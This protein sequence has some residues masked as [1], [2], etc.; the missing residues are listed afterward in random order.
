MTTKVLLFESDAEFAQILSTGLSSYGCETTVVDDGEEGISA[1]TADVPDLILLTIELPRMNGFSVCNKLKRNAGLK[2]VPLVLLSSEATEETFEQHKRL[3]TRADQ[4][5]RKPVTVEELA[6]K[7][8]GI[9]QLTKQNGEGADGEED[10]EELALDEDVE[11]EEV[12]ES[13]RSVESETDDAFGNI[14][15]AEVNAPAAD[16]VVMDDLELE[17]GD[18]LEV[19][20]PEPSAQEAQAAP[21]P[22]PTLDHGANEA[23]QSEAKELRQRIS[24][25]EEDLRS[26]RQATSAEA[27]AKAQVIQKKDAELSLLEKEIEQL[28][29][30]I[31]SNEGSGTAREFLDLRE[32]LNKKDKEILDIRDQLSS[33]EKQVV[34]LDDDNISLGRKNAD[35]SDQNTTLQAEAARLTKERDA[36]QAD[37]EQADKRGDDYKGKSERLQ[38]ELDAKIAELKQTIESHENALAT[39]EAREAALRDD[40]ATALREAALAAQEA[41]KRAVAEA[42]SQTE[43]KAAGEKEAALS[44]A[45]EEARKVREAAISAREVELKAEQDSK[46]AALHRAN[47]ESLRKL[48]AEHMQAAEE[49]AQAAEE[50]LSARQRELSDEKEAALLAQKEALLAERATVEKERDALSQELEIRTQERDADRAT[51]LERDNKIQELEVG[52][53]SARA[54]VIELRDKLEAE[55]GK[56]QRAR[57]KWGA[58]EAN[59][60][61]AKDALEGAATALSEALA[62][63]MP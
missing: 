41:Q 52:I 6:Q 58:D 49:A 37:K 18:G 8:D 63:P 39:R 48:R 23:L 29:S 42:V 61:V 24:Q 26:A 21:A 47:E 53:A 51:V 40:H 27:D 2:K 11:I 57:E 16:E 36:A 44:A 1:A 35:L 30:K 34:R 62:R 7:L 59:L 43:E 14:I 15:A 54:E 25:L 50:R 5:V 20:P 60:R 55:S 9:I 28:K 32:Q 13:I 4:Y 38:G 56:L 17:A 22:P 10:L 33:K 46:M 12:D 31:E 19:A 3:R 45:A